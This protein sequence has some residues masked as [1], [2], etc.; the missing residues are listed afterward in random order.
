MLSIA[1]YDL[2]KS[3]I[4]SDQSIHVLKNTTLEVNQAEMI[5]ITGTSGCGKSTLLHI[6]GL[7]DA[8][9][10]GRVMIGG[11]ELSAKMSEAP[12]VRNSELG[13]VFQ[14]HYLVEDL[15]A[16]EN[17]ALP[18]IIA[19]SSTS[20]AFKRAAELLETLG[21]AARLSRYPNQLSGGE[22]QRVSL[23]RALI[24]NPKIVLADEPTGNLDPEHSAE[25]WQMMIQL[26]KQ[27]EQ[28][29]VIVTHDRD[30]ALL[31][32]QTYDLSQGKLNLLPEN[33]Q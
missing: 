8:A 21:L 20:T 12:L 1:C 16:K 7:L 11:R 27:R 31:A 9:D 2:C 30:S 15:T 26:N 5:C 10:S 4:D 13:F 33:R 24:N 28:A 14:F 25:V 3:Y 23:A 18:M 17:V 29:F 22:Q 6:L 19:G 32:S